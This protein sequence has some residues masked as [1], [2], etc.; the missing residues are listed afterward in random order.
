MI[1]VCLGRKGINYI[2]FYTIWTKIDQKS[3]NFIKNHPFDIFPKIPI[4]N[5]YFQLEL[6]GVIAL[7][8]LTY[9]P[10]A[11]EFISRKFV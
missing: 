5:A 9:V 3:E 11:A 10:L 1:R 2:S 8:A 6:P 4:T 7:K